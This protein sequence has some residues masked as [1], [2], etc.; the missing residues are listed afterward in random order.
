ME[1]FFPPQV[2]VCDKN[3]VQTKCLPGERLIRIV[4]VG[5]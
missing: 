1:D 5:K 3:V 4:S 2:A